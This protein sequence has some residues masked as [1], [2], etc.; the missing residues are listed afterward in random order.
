MREVM[1]TPGVLGKKTTSNNTMEVKTI[2]FLSCDSIINLA[3]LIPGFQ[4]TRNRGS[5]S[6]YND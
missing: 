3:I 2:R 6:Y 5:Q 1:A 4:N